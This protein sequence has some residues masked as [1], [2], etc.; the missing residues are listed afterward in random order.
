M[1]QSCKLTRAEK[2]AVEMHRREM[3]AA[4]GCPCDQDTA[5]EDW[6]KH[7]A[8]KWRERWQAEYLAAQRAEIERYKWIESEKAC[9]DLGR[10]AVL[11]W[12][13]NHAAAWR[14]WYEQEHGELAD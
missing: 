6:L 10:G 5:L 7:H 1:T 8:V 11:N 14:M 2:S 9:C 13:Q 12:I 3:E 4:T